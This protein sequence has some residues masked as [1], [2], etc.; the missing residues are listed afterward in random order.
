MATSPRASFRAE[1]E[2]IYGL[3]CPGK[4]SS[5]P[6]MGLQAEPLQDQPSTFPRSFLGNYAIFINPG[7]P[8]FLLILNEL[9]LMVV[10]PRLYAVGD[11]N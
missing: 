7:H 1:G 3:V 4:P 2:D 5:E 11:F 6:Q 8:H 9:S 10:Q